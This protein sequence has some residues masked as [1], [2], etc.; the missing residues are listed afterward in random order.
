MAP[1]LVLPLLV[2]V[3]VLLKSL[4]VLGNEGRNGGVGLER[5]EGGRVEL[6]GVANSDD[7]EVIEVVEVAKL[8]GRGG[9]TVAVVT[10]VTTVNGLCSIPG[11]D[12]CIGLVEL[13][14]GAVESIEL[15]LGK[16]RENEVK[17]DEGGG[18]KLL[19]IDLCGDTPPNKL[20]PILLDDKNDPSPPPPTE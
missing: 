20:L 17:R 6:R 3:V 1:V 4:L 14:T 16:V 12:I 2:L 18:T 8:A 11:D 5:E 13:P 7:N 10:E 19:P 9:R 15:V